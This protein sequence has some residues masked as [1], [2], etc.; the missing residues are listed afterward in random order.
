M[1]TYGYEC[2]NEIMSISISLS[3]NKHVSMS[4]NIKR[5]SSMSIS[6]SIKRMRISV[7]T[8]NKVYVYGVR[9]DIADLSNDMNDVIVRYRLKC[10]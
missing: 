7:D 4:I 1:L 8:N 6:I 2:M 5:M 10:V 3:M 9:W